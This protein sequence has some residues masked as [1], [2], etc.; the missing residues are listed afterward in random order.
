[1]TDATPDDLLLQQIR[2]LLR[3]AWANPNEDIT[4]STCLG[5]DMGMDGDVAEAF[6]LAYSERF[7]VDLDDFVFNRY[8]GPEAP[9]NP[10]VF[11]FRKIFTPEWFELEEIT[12]ADLV[13][14]AKAGRW[15]K[16]D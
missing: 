16:D 13:K 14:A 8:F 1:M 9:F 2:D 3:E 11:V 10:F 7:K 12:V 6:M 15:D 4:E 5:R